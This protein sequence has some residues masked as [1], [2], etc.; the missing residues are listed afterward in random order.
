M[1]RPG[2][3][4]PLGLRGTP[5]QGWGDAAVLAAGPKVT[6]LRVLPRGPAVTAPGEP[7][8]RYRRGVPV[9]EPG[10][11]GAPSA[12]AE[13]KPARTLKRMK[14]GNSWEIISIVAIAL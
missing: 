10:Q 14:Q 13:V 5:P 4:R 9:P 12:P 6:E 3:A 11:R 7:R 8:A 2:P 1:W